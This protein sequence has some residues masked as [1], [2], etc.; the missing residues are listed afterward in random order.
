MGAQNFRN[1]LSPNDTLEETREHELLAFGIPFHFVSYAR[2]SYLL[3]VFREETPSKTVVFH[4]VEIALIDVCGTTKAS[5]EFLST[6][7]RSLKQR[8]L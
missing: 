2:Y 1:T 5:D 8:K 4:K 7:K 6:K 3:S